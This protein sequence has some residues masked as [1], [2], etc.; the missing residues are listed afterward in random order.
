[1]TRLVDPGSIEDL[2]G[3][4][5]HLERHYAK[6]VNS[7]EQVYILHSRTCRDRHPDLRECPFSRALDNRI[8][9][10]EWPTDLPVVL[11]HPFLTD[12][13]LT[14]GTP[15]S[16]VLAAILGGGRRYRYRDEATLHEA[17]SAVLDEAK[18]THEHEV[19]ITGGR[20]DFVVGRVGIEVK[21]KGSV[22][23][24]RRQLEG[25]SADRDINELLVVTTRPAHRAVP[26]R[27]GDKR[28]RVVVIGAWST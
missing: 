23:V 18:V 1:M 11:A 19:R 25:Y 14:P 5:R 10:D 15:D 4:R 24:L 6:A 16:A 13:H 22:E 3:V 20:I 7:E 21:V 17:L 27:V 8:N 2:V 9:V 26:D 28:V 12:G